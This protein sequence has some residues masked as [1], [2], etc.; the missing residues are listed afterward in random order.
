MSL[1][2]PAACCLICLGTVLFF[3]AEP[4]ASLRQQHHQSSPLLPDA[5]ATA[6]SSIDSSSFAEETIPKFEAETLSSASTPG[7]ES[8]EAMEQMEL[9]NCAVEDRGRPPSTSQSDDDAALVAIVFCLL[10][11]TGCACGVPDAITSITEAAAASRRQMLRRGYLSGEE[12]ELAVQ[13]GTRQNNSDRGD[14][15]AAASVRESRRRPLPRMCRE[16]D[17]AHYDDVPPGG[18][19]IFRRV[20]QMRSA[21]DS[22]IQRI[23]ARCLRGI[24]TSRGSPPPPRIRHNQAKSWRDSSSSSSS[25]PD[26]INVG[27]PWELPRVEVS[28]PSK[29]LGSVTTTALSRYGNGKCY[30]ELHRAALFTQMSPSRPATHLTL[31]LFHSPTVVPRRGG[32]GQGN[33]ASGA[34][35]APYSL[36]NEG[37][38]AASQW[39]SI[40]GLR[41][42]SY[43]L[44]QSIGHA[45]QEHCTPLSRGFTGS[46]N[47]SREPLAA[48]DDNSSDDLHVVACWDYY[49]YHLYLCLASLHAKLR[50][51]R[52][53]AAT[54]AGPR[55]VLAL[56]S[57]VSS[58]A[59]HKGGP[60]ASWVRY[61]AL[62]RAVLSET[63]VTPGDDSNSSAALER[64]HLSS[65]REG[66]PAW[67]PY[68]LAMALPPLR[69]SAVDVKKKE[70]R[71]KDRHPFAADVAMA[72]AA[73]GFGGSVRCVWLR[74]VGLGNPHPRSLTSQE[75]QAFGRDVVKASSITSLPGNISA[76]R[77]CDMT[78]VV[79]RHLTLV[80][81]RNA[82]R[83][84]AT[85]QATVN[86]SGNTVEVPAVVST[87]GPNLSDLTSRRNA[88]TLSILLVNRKRNFKMINGDAIAAAMADHVADML[89]SLATL[90]SNTSAASKSSA[91]GA[92]PG[93]SGLHNTREMGWASVVVRQ[94]ALEDCRRMEAQVALFRDA[95]IVVGTHGNGLT[96]SGVMRSGGTAA[97]VE[98]WP[99][100]S[101]NGN[102]RRFASLGGL[103]YV[104]VE[105]ATN[106]M[107]RDQTRNA[108]RARGAG[109][110][111]GGS[112]SASS[113]PMRFDYY[114]NPYLVLAG[115]EE[116]LWTVPWIRDL[117]RKNVNRWRSTCDDPVAERNQQTEKRK[118]LAAPPA[119]NRTRRGSPFCASWTAHRTRSM[120]YEA[121]LSA[122]QAHYASDLDS[123][124]MRSVLGGPSGRRYVPAECVSSA[125]T[126]H[127]GDVVSAR[128]LENRR[129]SDDEPRGDNDDHGVAMEHEGA[130]ILKRAHDTIFAPP[131]HPPPE[132]RRDGLNG[133]KTWEFKD[134]LYAAAPALKRQAVNKYVSDLRKRV[135]LGVVVL[136]AY[137]ALELNVTVSSELR[138]QAATL[139]ATTPRQPQP[140]DQ[141]S[142]TLEKT[143]SEG[144]M[145]EGPTDDGDDDGDQRPSHMATERRSNLTVGWIHLAAA[146]WRS[147]Q[148]S[149]H[150]QRHCSRCGLHS[151]EGYAR[152]RCLYA[153]RVLPLLVYCYGVD[154]QSDSQ[155]AAF[156]RQRAT[157]TAQ[158]DALQRDRQDWIASQQ[159]RYFRENNIAAAHWRLVTQSG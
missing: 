74:R 60:P 1:R 150:L 113:L 72:G 131:R 121:Q 23:T 102:Y 142:T 138:R 50:R 100:A 58:E 146:S 54:G 152:M 91:H 35:P 132:A 90:S 135:R 20:R 92:L 29:R 66:W 4:M 30:S 47:A 111:P 159:A 69:T 154:F 128:L 137:D 2:R 10:Q 12:V 52:T 103:H 134:V 144:A 108:R 118:R 116:S 88:S 87:P 11:A 40:T 114:A 125:L 9:Q 120:A 143:V 45:L 130:A 67:S 97:L 124:V 64:N 85:R 42:L 18:T 110:Y 57:A 115:V 44:S 56:P 133:M 48:I 89:S 151:P 36:C 49:G 76:S 41:I 149:R 136:D 22:A 126:N 33:D 86:I 98:I 81:A 109:G 96:W 75:W 99:A 70:E 46:M 63:T 78:T 77:E 25:S 13:Q 61:A 101:Y 65:L 21:D 105:H 51:R 7:V 28:P 71:R 59:F 148:L 157:L 141:I 55:H 158:Q 145:K 27:L 106:E 17:V 32:G 79:V 95:D 117:L 8:A 129:V 68:S 84:T 73:A 31:A 119:S 34:V 15:N 62:W 3:I 94:V 93:E 80:G 43:P 155:L 112:A 140:S 107:W 37:S 82:V 122:S 153:C 104:S 14:P 6:V 16:G 19:S 123:H 39:E 38:S 147:A 53:H 5:P 139:V 24:S 26:I 156:R 127:S 83:R